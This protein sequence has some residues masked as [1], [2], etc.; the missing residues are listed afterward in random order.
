MATKYTTIQQHEPLRVPSGWGQQER[1]F[2]AQ[3]EALF[4]D[5]YRRF[6]RIRMRDL[7]EPL[8]STI[9]ESADGVTE[10]KTSIVQTNAQIALKLDKTSPSVGVSNSAILINTDGIHLNSEGS[11]DV[12]GG[13]VNIKSGSSLTMQAVTD[14]DATINGGMIW[15]AKNLVVSTSAPTN[16]KPGLIWIKPTTTSSYAV[17][18]LSDDASPQ[19]ATETVYYNGTWTGDALSNSAFASPVNIPC[20]GV[21]QGAAPSGSYS[22]QYTVKVYFWKSAAIHSANAHVYLSNTVGGMDVDCGSQTFTASGWFEKTVTSNVWLGNGGTIFITVVKDE[23]DFAVYKNKPFSVNAALT[24]Y[25]EG[26]G[27]DPDPD[28]PA[29]VSGFVSCDVYYYAG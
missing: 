4:D 2:I 11:I 23:A 24:G 22:C 3:L 16:P 29:P 19:A 15:H 6:N 28:P 13:T 21:A 8:Q 27:T 18:A 14:E 10:V 1:A 25:T 20:Y 17:A 9:Q 5:V 7:S 12:D 26:G